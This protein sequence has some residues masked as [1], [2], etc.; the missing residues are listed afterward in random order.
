[1]NL[2]GNAF[3]FAW[4]VTLIKWLQ[5]T[6]GDKAVSVVSSFSVFG[7][8]M[9]MILILGAVYWGWSKKT[10]KAIGVTMIMG[11]LWSTMIKN[12]FVRR[13]PYFDD[14]DIKILRPVD[15]KADIYDISAQ[16]WSFPS[17]HST[18]ALGMTGSLAKETKKK[19]FRVLAVVI[20]VLVGLSRVTVGAHYPTD[21]IGGW[22]VAAAALIIVPLLR[23][24][25]RNE[26]LM[27]GLLIL[28]SLPG[29]FFCRSTDYFSAFGLLLGFSAGCLFEEKYVQFE[30]TGN[31]VRVALR[32][33]GG[34]AIFFGM[35]SLLKLPFPKEFLDSGV[36]AALL[37]RAARY[38]VI[39]FLEFAVYPMLFKATAG[40]WK[41]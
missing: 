15:K 34:V 28:L 21:I 37:V 40:L 11:I 26:K 1:M 27:F 31:I 35:N 36:Y 8:E 16:G 9:V 12:I 10:G 25:I 7:E 19:V 22:L 5:N 32:T 39:A 13:R 3:S 6:L 17:I 30:N 18:I 41:S 23:K 4:E 24:K 14:P 38:A 29:M 2:S 20:P 33:I